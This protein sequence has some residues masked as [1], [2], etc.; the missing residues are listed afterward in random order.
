[1][2][3]IERIPDVPASPGVVPFRVTGHQFQK[4][5][6]LF[7]QLIPGNAYTFPNESLTPQELVSI[8]T[9]TQT[10]QTP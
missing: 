5:R 8:V 3:G 2:D 10:K 6:V 7:R 9:A 4:H 1:M